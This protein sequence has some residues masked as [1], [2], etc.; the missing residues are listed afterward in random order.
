MSNEQKS[1]SDALLASC[2]SLPFQAQG[3]GWGSVNLYS[4]EDAWSRALDS[5]FFGGSQQNFEFARRLGDPAQSSLVMAAVRF[6]GNTLPEA[7]LQ[8]KKP[9]KGTK[10][11]KGEF[12]VVP[13]HPM[14]KL[15]NRPNKYYSGSTLKKALAFS[16][17]IAGDAYLIKI[18]N[19]NHTEVVELWWEPHWTIRPA[20]PIDGSEFISHYE[21]NRNGQW[22]RIEVDEVIHFRDGISPFDQRRGLLFLLSITRELYGDQEASNFYANLMG[23]SAV[24]PFMVAVEKDVEMTKEDI[25]DFQNDLMRNTSGDRKGRPIVTKGAKAYKLGWSPR[26]LDLREGRFMP[27]DRFC[28]VTGIPGVVMELGTGHEHSIYN[29]VESA[30]ERA[31]RSYIVPLWNHVEE[32]LE[33]QLLPDFE[34]EDSGTVLKHDLTQVQALQE[35]ADKKATRLTGLYEKGVITRREARSGNNF[36]PSNPEDEESDNLFFVLKGGSLVKPNEEPVNQGEQIIDIATGEARVGGTPEPTQPGFAPGDETSFGDVGPYPDIAAKALDNAIQ[37]VD[38]PENYDSLNIPR[39]A[40]PQV[41]SKHRGAMVNFLRGRGM[42]VEKATVRPGDL[43]PSQR[44]YAPAKVASARE[45]TGPERPLLVS[46]DNYVADGHH[47]WAADIMD[48]PQE[49]IPI[50]KIDASIMETLLALSQFPSSGVKDSNDNSKFWNSN[51][52][53]NG[54]KKALPNKN[55]FIKPEDFTQAVR[56][57]RSN[58]FEVAASLMTASTDKKKSN[59]DSHVL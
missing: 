15:W 55:R 3:S 25:R 26:E 28:A 22:I 6:V 16:W 38:F 33:V 18:W 54:N 48:S 7:P 57:L 10:G 53:N 9:L 36:G 39:T 44:E 21:V 49:E 45:W 56:W 14:I 52:N 34:G 51:G 27:E 35:D 19:K 4:S 8:A 47:Q 23:G 32:E 40:M 20:F 43:K 24:P 46:N 30:M 59:G 1:I 50:Y 11:Q 13:D 37:W 17:V 12:E 2:K 58:R 5:S 42:K 41:L 31:Y 29:N